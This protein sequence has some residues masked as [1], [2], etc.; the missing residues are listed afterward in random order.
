MAIDR[1]NRD[2]HIRADVARVSVIPCA[3]SSTGADGFRRTRSGSRKVS[4]ARPRAVAAPSPPVALWEG[5][6]LA[7]TVSCTDHFKIA[8]ADQ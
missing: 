4:S 6:D 1:G 5:A 2:D 8:N 7:T 3:N